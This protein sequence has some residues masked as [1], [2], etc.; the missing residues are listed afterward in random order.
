M[1]LQRAFS[2]F[3]SGCPGAALLLLRLAVGGVASLQASI[4]I[5]TQD[6]A[7]GEILSAALVIVITLALIV[8]FITPVA[9]VLLTIGGMIVM[10]DRDIVGAL[11]M[12]ESWTARVEFI[13]L[14]GVLICLGPGAFSLDARLYGR[15]EVHV[16]GD[17]V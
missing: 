4:I 14:S 3:P 5:A 13:V 17:G 16:N 10:L 1:A 9:S 11:P 7:N 15:R 6:A 8:G 12:F 2:S